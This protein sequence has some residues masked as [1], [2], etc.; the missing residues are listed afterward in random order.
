MYLL[1]EKRQDSGGFIF[2]KTAT[3]HRTH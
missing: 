3:A 1:P 2:Q